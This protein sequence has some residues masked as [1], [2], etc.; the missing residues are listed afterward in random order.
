MTKKIV[1]QAILYLLLS[2]YVSLCLL[3]EEPMLSLSFRDTDI[4]DVLRGIAMQNGINIVPDNSVTGN[5]TIH[6][7]NVS[8]D[9]GLKTL[10]EMNGFEYEK[11]GDIYLVRRQTTSTS[12]FNVSFQNGKLSVDADNVDVKQLL[13]DISKK[14]GLNIVVENDLTG[15][16]TANVSNIPIED[17]LYVIL[18]PN[19]FV[20]KEN[21]GV[22]D[23]RSGK[24][25]QQQRGQG[26]LSIL[27]RKGV[28]YMTSRTLQSL[29]SLQRLRHSAR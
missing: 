2:L 13:R 18:E 6:L 21:N 24:Q 1:L 7:Q 16:V 11:K 26:S 28:L 14:T 4:R 19:G 27:H 5:I 9:V 10:L 3:A 23:I 17:V 8:L 12:T 15:N 29:M 22:Y 25:Q 20:V